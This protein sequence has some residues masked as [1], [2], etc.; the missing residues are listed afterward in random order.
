MASVTVEAIYQD[1]ALKPL[2]ILD[3]P[4]KVHVRVQVI[5]IPDEEALL[6][7]YRFKEQ[8]VRL[9]LLQEVRVPSRVP[10]WDRTPIQVKGKPLSQTIIEERR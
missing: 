7:E 5:P 8:L 3:L 2:Q 10:E 6:D 9:G 4:D 1:G